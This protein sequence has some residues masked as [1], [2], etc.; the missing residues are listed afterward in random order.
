M[1]V[2]MSKTNKETKKTE[3]LLKQ[4]EFLIAQT[5]KEMRE[6]FERGEEG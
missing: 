5:E 2:K 1:G 6:D 4:A 3:L